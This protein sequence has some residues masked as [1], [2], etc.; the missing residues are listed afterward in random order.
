LADVIVG[1][2]SVAGDSL[3]PSPPTFTGIRA[4]YLKGIGAERLVVLDID[5]ILSDPKI[6]VHEEV[7]N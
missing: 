4:D 1:V 2:R 7:D 5:R 6:I 3:Q